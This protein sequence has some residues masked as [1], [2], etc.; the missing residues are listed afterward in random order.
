MRTILSNSQK[1][2][3]PGSVSFPG[4]S[5]GKE[6]AGQFRGY[7]RHGFDLGREDPLEEGMAT[8][9]CI[10]QPGESHRKRS[11]EGCGLWDHKESDTTE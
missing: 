1:H 5:S 11:L 10:L 8:Y 9:S 6:P 2:N 7:D 3:S 4:G